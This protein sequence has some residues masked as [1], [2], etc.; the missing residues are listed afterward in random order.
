MHHPS[1]CNIA[2][3][4]RGSNH[5][6]WGL[7]PALAVICL[8]AVPV[9]SSGQ[10]L[11]SIVFGDKLNSSKV[12]FGLDGG[13]S[14]SDLQGLPVSKVRP[15]FNLGF[16]FDIKLRD[17]SWM[18][19]TGV[20][21]K[22]S[23]GARDLPVYDL[24]NPELNNVFS[25][26]AVIRRLGY[27]NVPVTMRYRFTK[28][29]SLE[30]GPMF[31]LINNGVDEF[32]ASV[33]DDDDLIHTVKIR[34]QYHPLD[35]GLIAGVGYRLMKGNGL[36]LGVRYYFG[37][38]DVEIDDSGPDVFNRSF[39]VYAGIPIGVSSKKKKGH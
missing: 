3:V 4:R 26:G 25:N 33:A 37:F 21:V 39:Y 34:D 35:F 17:T 5:L 24:N 31:G 22:S 27:F 14:F 28:R 7:I 13:M 12:E 16:Y 2:I 1:P 15:A 11:I 10:V 29:M 8:C 38:V 6:P 36:N 9:R 30:A 32:T 19:H 20:M 23:F 18:V